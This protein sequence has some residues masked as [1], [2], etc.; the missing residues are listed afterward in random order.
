MARASTR[1]TGSP[2]GRRSSRATAICRTCDT[3]FRWCWSTAGPGQ[4][5]FARSRR[6]ST[7]CCRRSRRAGST[8]SGCAS[9]CCGSSAKYVRCS[10]AAQPARCRSC[11]RRPHRSSR[12]RTTRRRQACSPISPRNCSW[13]ATWSTATGPCPRACSTHAWQAAQQRKGKAFRDHRRAPHGQAFRHPARGLHSLG[14]GAAAR[15]AARVAW[16]AR[17]GMS[18]TSR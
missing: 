5:R 1:S 7:R 9:T 6:S 10:R 18:S 3:T 2:C 8:A 14:S 4:A 11:G 13:T 16:V 15:G 17:T 12:C